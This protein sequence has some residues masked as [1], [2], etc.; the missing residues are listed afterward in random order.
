MWCKQSKCTV[1]ESLKTSISNSVD[2]SDLYSVQH[3][4]F[5]AHAATYLFMISGGEEAD[6]GCCGY[7]LLGLSMFII[8]ITFPI[9]ICACVKVKH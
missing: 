2:E 3:C 9:A 6:Y 7:L 8:L 1:I 5:F 4:T